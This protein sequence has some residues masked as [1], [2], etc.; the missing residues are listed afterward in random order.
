MGFLFERM[1]NLTIF[2]II[3]LLSSSYLRS[4][5]IYRWVDANGVKNFSNFPATVPEKLFMDK[6]V[7]MSEKYISSL[8]LHNAVVDMTEDNFEK[9]Y[10]AKI[11]KQLERQLLVNK[12][13]ELR[14]RQ[15]YLQEQ[16]VINKNS[17]LRTKREFDNLIIKGYFTD[18]SIIELKRLQRE[19][20]QISLE[21]GTI[22]PK[23]QKIISH[24][25]QRGIS[26]I[27]FTN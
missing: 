11:E 3:F 5:T 24:A 2:V 13:K 1:R 26:K 23:K 25:G 20:K 27:H 10:L 14:D 6:T 17:A 12:Y 15:E 21:L 18:H 9:E 4:A 7:Q 19:M 16:L 8:P 22:E